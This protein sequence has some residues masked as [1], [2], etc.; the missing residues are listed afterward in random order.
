MPAEYR[1]LSPAKLNLFLKIIGGP[2]SDKDFEFFKRELYGAIY[3]WI[4]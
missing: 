4:F 1:E 3:W 2:V